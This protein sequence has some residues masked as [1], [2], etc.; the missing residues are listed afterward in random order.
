MTRASIAAALLV[1]ALAA[2][3]RAGDSAKGTSAGAF[4]RLAPGARG[5]ALGEAF[6][7]VADDAYAAWYNPAGLAFL[8][9]VEAAGAHESRFES[10]SYD[11]AIIAAP[12]LAWSDRPRR[13]NAYGV[14]ALAVYSL[15]TKDI[16]RRGLVETDAPSGT[17][18]ASDRAVAV[19][20]AKRVIDG[21]LSL[22][23][24]VK[25]VDSVLDSSRA[26]TVTWDGA[27]LWRGPRTW[28][29]AGVRG[30]GGSL[31]YKSEAD[32]VSPVYYAGASLHSGQTWLLSSELDVPARE[33]ASLGLG[34]EHRWQAAPDF[35]ASLRAGYRTGRSDSGV[36]AG[37]SLGLAA[38]WRAL[39]VDVAWS[40]GGAL[41]DVFTYSVLV[42]FGQR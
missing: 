1:A 14:M 39:E 9:T 36:L 19:S 24:T 40:P 31:R 21:P 38:T 11:V 10:M 25:V 23:A 42:R 4:L 41:A 34:L 12:V 22:G 30:L 27:C 15:S 16:A 18:G 29:A 7:G 2:D 35:S 17:F 3:G 5:A 20:Y 28:V 6:A 8:E 32:A 37:A 13:A 26:E 33:A